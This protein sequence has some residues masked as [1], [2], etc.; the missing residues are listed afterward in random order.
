[1]GARRG[2][3][4]TAS[5]IEWEARAALSDRRGGI[6]ARHAGEAPKLEKATIRALKKQAP[7]RTLKVATRK[8][9]EM[10]LKSS[11]RSCPRPSAAR[12][13]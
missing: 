3:A 9:S 4:A 8:A 11:T 13:T 2:G 6:P 12:P 1:M 10:A 7:K 5:A